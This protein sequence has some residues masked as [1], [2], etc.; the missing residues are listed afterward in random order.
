MTV[1]L[2]PRKEKVVFSWLLLNG[3]NYFRKMY[4]CNVKGCPKSESPF[5]LAKGFKKHYLGHYFH[6][7]QNIVGKPEGKKCKF[8][9][10][11]FSTTQNVIYHIAYYHELMGQVSDFDG[12]KVT[13]KDSLNEGDDGM[14]N[15]EGG[16]KE[17]DEGPL[18][19]EWKKVWGMEDGEVAVEVFYKD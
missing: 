9:D 11:E 15:G 17:A 18:V 19:S 7:I 14:N 16:G 5:K 8:C 13:K 4:I 1:A 12:C 3:Y 2:K 10:R 6:V